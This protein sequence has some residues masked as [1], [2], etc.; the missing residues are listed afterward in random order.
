MYE[1]SFMK[2]AIQDVRGSVKNHDG[3]LCLMCL[4]AVLW[5]NIDRVYYACH[6]EDEVRI[7]FR[8]MK[9]SEMLGEHLNLPEGFTRKRIGNFISRFF[10]NTKKWIRRFRKSAIHIGFRKR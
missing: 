4:A 1:P 8:D 3:G 5:A 10:T 2:L 6:A 9:L 7:G